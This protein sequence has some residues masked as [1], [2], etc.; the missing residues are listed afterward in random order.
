MVRVSIIDVLA[1]HFFIGLG[2]AAFYAIRCAGQQKP[3]T[4]FRFDAGRSAWLRWYGVAYFFEVA[5]SFLMGK[6]L[7]IELGLSLFEAAA[8]T[9]GL[10]VVDR[11]LLL[12]TQATPP[13]ERPVP[14]PNLTDEEQRAEAIRRYHDRVRGA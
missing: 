8:L 13:S 10:Y 12:F 3:R 7:Y 14:T 5:T 9:A 11:G 1:I 2:A 6:H 4:L